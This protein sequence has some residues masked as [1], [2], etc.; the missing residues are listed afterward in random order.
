MRRYEPFESRLIF[1]L[2]DPALRH[3]GQIGPRLAGITSVT[4]DGIVTASRSLAKIEPRGVEGAGTFPITRGDSPPPLESAR[5]EAKDLG[6]PEGSRKVTVVIASV[7]AESRRLWTERLQETFA[8]CA[9]TKPRALGRITAN[10][11]PEILVLDLALPR[12]DRAYGLQAIHRLS[13][14]T[15][16]LALTD[17][18]T[19]AEGVLAL[20]AGARG[21]CA[22]SIDPA[23][24]KEVLRALQ[25]GEFWFP[26][27]LVPGLIAELQSLLGTGE[28]ALRP[29]AALEALTKRQRMVADLVGQGASNK[30]IA[31]RLKISERTVKAHLTEAYRSAGV[32]D[33]LQ[34][35]L[36]LRGQSHRPE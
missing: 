19:E 7:L 30:E 35:A 31:S 29:K 5:R 27:N 34:L 9:V 24:L 33:R 16:I 10:L 28:E 13:P 21:Y 25:N 22:R 20:K 32:S 26:R 23:H 18:P 8:V 6:Q 4:G 36:L 17:A 15:K 1:S 2:C 14:S 11:K 12:L 3:L